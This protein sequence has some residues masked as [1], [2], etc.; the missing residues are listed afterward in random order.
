MEEPELE[1]YEDRYGNTLLVGDLVKNETIN[2][3]LDYLYEVIALY[4]V[5]GQGLAT[6]RKGLGGEPHTVK[7]SHLLWVKTPK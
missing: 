4:K 3:T 1:E 5:W 6:I 2:G 7:T